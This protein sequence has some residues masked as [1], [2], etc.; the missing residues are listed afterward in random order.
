MQRLTEHIKNSF[1]ADSEEEAKMVADIGDTVYCIFNG[2]IIQGVINIIR[3]TSSGIT[4]HMSGHYVKGGFKER[5]SGNYKTSSFG[6]TIFLTKIEAS[7][8]LFKGDK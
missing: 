8:V 3:L 6:K 2:A 5:Y 4:Y 7:N 1:L